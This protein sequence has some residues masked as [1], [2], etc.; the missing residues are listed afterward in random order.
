[1]SLNRRTEDVGA[2]VVRGGRIVDPSQGIDQIGDLVLEGGKVVG[3]DVTA[4]DNAEVIDA[5]DRIVSPGI[6]DMNV[7]LREP[8]FEEDETIATGT[9]AAVAGG[10]TTVACM[11]NTD[12]PVDTQASVEFI[13]LQA[14]RS[15]NCNVAVIACVSKDRAGEQLA[16]MGSLKNSGAVAFSD[17]TRPIHNTGLMRRAL[18]YSRMFD[19]PILSHPEI[20]ELT[21]DGI[22]H[23]GLTSAVLGLGGF[24]SEAE[25]V[26]VSRDI[27]LAEA[28]GSRVH[29][30]NL[31]TMG[32]VGLIRRAKQRDINVTCEIT[33]THFSTT[34]EMM[35]SFNTNCKLN[36]PMRS[37][38]HVDACIE[39]LKDGTIDVIVSG[40][41]P[42]S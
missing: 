13:Q 9:A 38:A 16:E 42:R 11:P 32:A 40:H 34:D 10:I 7:Q 4:P 29:I 22:M 37:Q 20:R 28:T 30:M 19:C 14:E 12:P 15:G 18:Q 21:K 1:M 41:A 35:R 3:I 36:P 33:A 6:V 39:G 27:R 31:S 24:P 25:D 5:S 26:M 8:G 17:A 23:D 2:V